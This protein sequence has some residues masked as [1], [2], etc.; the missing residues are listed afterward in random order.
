MKQA[1]I[2]VILFLSATSIFASTSEQAYLQL[3]R[4]LKNEGNGQ[5]AIAN[6]KSALSRNP[7]NKEALFELATLLY[8]QG[9]TEQAASYFAA[10]V[11]LDPAHFEATLNLAIAYTILGHTE[12]A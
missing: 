2:K 10:L 3:A 4:V 7:N 5:E 11:T 1:S 9:N 12:K 6:F 8:T